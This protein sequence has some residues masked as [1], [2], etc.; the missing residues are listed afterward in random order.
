MEDIREIFTLPI[1]YNSKSIELSDS[2]I[3]DLELLKRSE[4]TDSTDDSSNNS[5]YET[6]FNLNSI[7]AKVTVDVGS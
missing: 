3:D 4:T 7:F 5:I 6:L 1:N 2:V